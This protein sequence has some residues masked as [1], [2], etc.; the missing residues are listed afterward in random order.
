MAERRGAIT[1]E[2]D[3][4]SDLLCSFRLRQE[5]GLSKRYEVGV[6]LLGESEPLVRATGLAEYFAIIKETE[7]QGAEEPANVDLKAPRRC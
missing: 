7:E 3:Y 4:A 6:G 2:G 1:L 5:G